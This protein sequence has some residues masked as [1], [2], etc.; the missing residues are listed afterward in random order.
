MKKIDPEK[1]PY[2]GRIRH[3]VSPNLYFP[4]DELKKKPK[5][6]PPVYDELD[7]NQ[8]F[9][10]G[11]PPDARDIGCGKGLLLFEFAAGNP[12]MN[13]LG[14]EIRKQIVD[15]NSEVIEG[16]NIG[17]CANIWYSVAN[18]LPFIGDSSISKV[19]YLFPDPWVKRRQMKRRAFN[20][21]LLNEISR[22]MK[23]EGSL[24]LVTDVE[25]VHD[26]HLHLL[27]SNPAF[28]FGDDI[29]D[30]QWDL[31]E[32]NKEKFCKKKNIPYFRIIAKPNQK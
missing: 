3:H 23:P 27:K 29:S 9:E 10:N 1:Y 21:D 18:G 12:G 2:P 28:E 14:I 15:W 16:E 13:I 8:Y 6:Y 7:W 20:D 32:T 24:Y 5:N 25:E 4:L 11:N 22:V 26:Y 17:N 30:E 19:F 31:P